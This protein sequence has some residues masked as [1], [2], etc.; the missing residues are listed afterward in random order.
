MTPIYPWLLN[1]DL[2]EIWWFENLMILPLLPFHLFIIIYNTN[3]RIGYFGLF[4]RWWFQFCATVG[5]QSWI[6]D[7]GF[8]L[9]WDRFCLFLSLFQFS[10]FFI[11]SQYN[12]IIFYLYFQDMRQLTCGMYGHQK[13]KWLG[14]KPNL[15]VVFIL[16]GKRWDDFVSPFLSK[17]FIFFY[18]SLKF[19]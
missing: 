1:Q 7:L 2:G 9:I 11:I 10:S 8:N 12:L 18:C 4:W 15:K 3:N 16:I 5:T 6:Y 17:S 19:K 13:D 14:T